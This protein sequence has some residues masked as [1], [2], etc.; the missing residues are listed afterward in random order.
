MHLSALTN[1]VCDPLDNMCH[2]A[3]MT[4]MFIEQGIQWIIQKYF[5]ARSRGGTC[6]VITC[7][8]RWILISTWAEFPGIVATCLVGTLFSVKCKVKSQNS[9]S[10][11]LHC[12]HSARWQE[13]NNDLC[14]NIKSIIRLT[15]YLISKFHL[16]NR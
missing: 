3:N 11:S 13:Q 12:Q 2:C 5:E 9:H 16:K 15:S 14:F 10:R 6:G 1:G 8:L 4:Y 7:V